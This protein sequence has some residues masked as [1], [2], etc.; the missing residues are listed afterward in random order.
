M[1]DIFEI[2]FPSKHN[3][4][5][6]KIT[7]SEMN[8]KIASSVSLHQ[9]VWSNLVTWWDPTILTSSMPISLNLLQSLLDSFDKLSNWSPVIN[10]FECFDVMHFQLWAFLRG[11][12]NDNLLHLFTDHSKNILGRNLF[13]SFKPSLKTSESVFSVFVNFFD[14]SSKEKERNFFLF[15]Q[16]K[17]FLFFSSKKFRDDVAKF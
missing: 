3:H 13:W 11:S 14:F 9:S 16:F 5:K 10:I 8:W 15:L 7:S 1:I 4:L 2:F 17:N 12:S 6:C